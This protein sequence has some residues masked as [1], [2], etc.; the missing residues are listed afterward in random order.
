MDDTLTYINMCE[1]SEIQ[2]DWKPKDG[3]FVWHG[4]EGEEAFGHHE[5]PVE[6]RIVILSD[7]ETEA[8]WHN[9][10]WLPRQDDLQGMI[11]RSILNETSLALAKR[12]GKWLEDNSF[13]GSCLTEIVR[14]NSMEQLW[15]A[16]VMKEKYNKTWNGKDWK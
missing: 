6:G 2:K 7:I 15:L 11:D 3:D 8:W 10:L 9:W 14:K 13:I 16:F 5:Y 12:F 1:K 4:D